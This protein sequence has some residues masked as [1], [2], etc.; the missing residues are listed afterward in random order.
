MQDLIKITALAITLLLVTISNLMSE[1]KYIMKS[2]D[3]YYGEV[4]SEDVN[5]FTIREYDSDFMIQLQ[6]KQIEKI[7]PLYF[8][9]ITKNAFEIKGYIVEKHPEFLKVKTSDGVI[10]EVARAQIQQMTFIDDPIDTWPANEPKISKLSSNQIDNQNTEDIKA[11]PQKYR[12]VPQV[13]LH[14]EEEKSLGDNFAFIGAGLGTPAVINLIGGYHL[15][16]CTLRV[17]GSFGGYYSGAQS[18]VFFNLIELFSNK[19]SIKVGVNSGFWIEARKDEYPEYHYHKDRNDR[20]VEVYTSYKE[21]IKKTGYYYYGGC[22]NLSIW[23]FFME[24]GFSEGTGI[25]STVLFQGQVG[26][27][28]SFDLK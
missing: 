19:L 12:G 4:I 18:T 6:K 13:H 20:L 27:T 7:E 8:N 26:F 1:E 22:V 23:G 17:H 24:V 15:D 9:I 10:F 14:E 3:I 5:A 16:F 11:K 28:Y 21:Y 25:G 2:G